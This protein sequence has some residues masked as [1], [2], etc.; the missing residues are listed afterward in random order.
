MRPL[1][2]LPVFLALEGKRAIVCG[3]PRRR[4]GRPNCCRPPAPGR[5][6]LRWPGE[7]LRAL[8]A[9]A[10]AM[11][12]I[13]FTAAPGKPADFAGAAVAIG[14]ITDDAGGGAVRRRRPPRR[15]S[16][17]CHRQAAAVRFHLRRDRQP[18]AARDRHLDRRR[19]A[20]VRP[21]DPRQDRGPA[22][23][24]LC[25]L[26]GGRPAL[27]HARSGDRSSGGG[28]PAVLAALHRDGRPTPGPRSRDA[29]FR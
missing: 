27:A 10:A 9:D 8:A 16:G 24:R 5:S 6:L 23:A 28:A 19:R 26:G 21:G 29:R 2:R 4:P 17:Q 1:S 12:R 22:A 18:L 11:A 15:H 3:T 14:A 20:G 7:E 25:A 13:S